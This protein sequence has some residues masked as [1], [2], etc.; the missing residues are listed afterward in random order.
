M[1][2]EYRIKKSKGSIESAIQ[3]VNAANSPIKKVQP[4]VHL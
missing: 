4:I 3:A 2:L 1:K